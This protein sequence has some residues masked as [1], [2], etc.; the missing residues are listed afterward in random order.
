M[1]CDYAVANKGSPLGSKF[2]IY[3]PTNIQVAAT[4]TGSD[5]I[6]QTIG[7]RR[8]SLFHRLYFVGVL[9]HGG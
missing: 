8:N 7:D 5:G 6:W 2:D 3:P 1:S 9:N 4:I